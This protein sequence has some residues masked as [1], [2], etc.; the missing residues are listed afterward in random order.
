MLLIVPTSWY[1]IPNTEIESSE[2]FPMQHLNTV[3]DLCVQY[4]RVDQWSKISI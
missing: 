4:Q 3:L 1:K 2:K